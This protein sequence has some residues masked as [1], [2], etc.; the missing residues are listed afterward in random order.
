MNITGQQEQ[1]VTGVAAGISI[2]CSFL[3][4]ATFVCLKEVRTITRQIIIYIT[5]ADLCTSVANLTGV[6]FINTQFGRNGHIKSDFS[7]ALCSIQS[8]VSSTSSLCSFLWTMTFSLVL[9]F[10]LVK[11]DVRRVASMLPWLHV[12]CWLLPLAINIVALCL[13]KLG[14][15]TSNNFIKDESV[16]AGWCWIGK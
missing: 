4:L 3:I 11:E 7:P 9:Y 15:S 14:Y 5:L 13:G 12:I 8:F 16:T 1:I 6:I 10:I 2:C